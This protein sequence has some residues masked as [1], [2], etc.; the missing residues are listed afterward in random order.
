[1]DRAGAEGLPQMARV[2]SEGRI[3]LA[4]NSARAIGR[5]IF[6]ADLL[7]P[8]QSELLMAAMARKRAE[9]NLA[10]VEV[11]S[12][13]METLT[14]ALDTQ[15]PSVVLDLPVGQLVLQVLNSR[16]EMTSVQEGQNGRLIRAA[17]PIS[18]NMRQSEVA[19]V[20]VVDDYV[21]ESLLMKWE[22]ITRQYAE[23]KQ[24]KAMK[25]PI[26][27]GMYLFIAVVAMLILFSAT[28][29]G[30]YVARGITVPIQRLAEATNA[31]ARGNLN[32]KIA[33]KATDEIG[34]LIDSFNHMTQDLRVGK[35]KLEQVNRSLQ[36]SNLELEDRRA[37][38]EAV[39]DTIAAGVL[40]IDRAGT[41]S[42]FNPS[43]E[44]ILGVWGD[45]LRGRSAN[46][47]FKA[48]GLD[49][50]QSAFDRILADQRDSLTMEGALE[51]QGKFLTIGLNVSR[52]RNQAGEDL[53]FVL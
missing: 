9:H 13:K 53:G 4:S 26:K 49:L 6:R 11:Y 22:G 27:A 44:R 31:I 18:S 28:W 50:F 21:P 36:Q 24:T 40:S 17:V 37:Y 25:N 41:I 8:D 48:L 1:P 3:A 39:V 35:T 42:T 23:Y 47:A 32:V 12:H 38:T 34:T 46:E 19:G 10:G 51:M 30:F 5:E 2:Y 7:T 15:V 20:V 33:A 29:F 52:M 14:K 16:R 43:A 45:Q